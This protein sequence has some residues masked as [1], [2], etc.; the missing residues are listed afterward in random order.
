MYYT[1][2]KPSVA[3]R[4][5]IT[6]SLPPSLL[7][8]AE[9]LAREERRTKSELLREAFRFYVETRTARRAAMRERA[10]AVMDAVH[11]RTKGTSANEI[12]TI[13][14]EAVAAARGTKRRA[15]A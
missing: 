7:K 3:T 8:Q 9:Q 5:L 13:V 11:E 4:K 1:K 15:S 10:L 2:E 12:R 14:R 6:I